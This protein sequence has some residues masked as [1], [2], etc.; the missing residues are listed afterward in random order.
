MSAGLNHHLPKVSF[1]SL[2]F[3]SFALQDFFWVPADDKQTHLQEPTIQPLKTMNNELIKVFTIYTRPKNNAAYKTYIVYGSTLDKQRICVSTQLKSSK[4]QLKLNVCVPKSNSNDRY[5]ITCDVIAYH[6]VHFVSIRLIN[7]CQSGI[8]LIFTSE[9]NI[10]QFYE[11][12]GAQSSISG[13]NTKMKVK[14]CKVYT[15]ECQ[16]GDEIC[17]R[18]NKTSEFDTLER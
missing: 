18:Y 16:Q 1:F 8:D 11:N 3:F 4:K 15:L 6:L 14:L 9:R 12:I 10:L 7:K 17:F 13:K 5:A 2:T